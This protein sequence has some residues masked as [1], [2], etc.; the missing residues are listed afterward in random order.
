MHYFQVGLLEGESLPVSKRPIEQEIV[1]VS[2]DFGYYGSSIFEVVLGL[3]PVREEEV[4]ISLISEG[5]ILIK[6]FL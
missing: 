6:G 1:L 3:I 4:E 2:K 5:L